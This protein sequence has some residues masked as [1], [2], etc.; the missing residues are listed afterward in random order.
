M[1]KFLEFTISVLH[2]LQLPKSKSNR[3][4]IN[5]YNLSFMK[6][7]EKVEGLTISLKLAAII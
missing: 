5:E 6:S 1:A 7:A 2:M 4:L 3:K